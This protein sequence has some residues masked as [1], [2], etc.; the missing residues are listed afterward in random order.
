LGRE[1]WFRI[2]AET[3]G[4]TARVST[5]A[6][7]ALA[8]ICADTSGV[9]DFGPFVVLEGDQEGPM[10][11]V[12]DLV[13]KAKGWTRTAIIPTSANAI[14]APDDYGWHAVGDSDDERLGALPTEAMAD[15]FDFDS[16][17]PMDVTNQASPA[18]RM[19]F[20]GATSPTG[21]AFSSEDTALPTGEPDILRNEDGSRTDGLKHH[22]VHTM[23]AV[24]GLARL[25]TV[26]PA[27]LRGTS[28]KIVSSEP[29]L[30]GILDELA[31][32][33]EER[34]DVMAR[35][36]DRLTRHEPDPQRAWASWR[37]RL[38]L[39]TLSSHTL[40]R[41][42]RGTPIAAVWSSGEFS[43]RSGRMAIACIPMGQ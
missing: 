4:L 27:I 8:I 2:A 10:G 15:G 34:S 26:D 24:D 35:L 3:P 30:A 38:S 37:L 40:P 29:D 9:I 11:V 6:E 25:V 12:L 36:V 23:L 33:A 32:S 43:A 20:Q 28:K 13:A 1:D 22:S 42:F 5:L 16:P 17:F 14:T 41:A 39:G 21:D 19:I 18:I 31:T 7:G